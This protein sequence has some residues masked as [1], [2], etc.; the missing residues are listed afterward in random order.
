[1]GPTKGQ[2]QLLYQEEATKVKFILQ[3]I[4]I[5]IIRIYIAQKSQ[6]NHESECA[7]IAGSIYRRNMTRRVTVGWKKKILDGVWRRVGKERI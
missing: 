5:I 3:Q 6:I 1:M 7:D 4:L 2:C